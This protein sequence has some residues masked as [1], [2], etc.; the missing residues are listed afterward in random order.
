[1]M[2]CRWS[3]WG[4]FRKVLM[5]WWSRWVLAYTNFWHILIWGSQYFFFVWFVWWTFDPIYLRFG[6]KS[7]CYLEACQS[8]HISSGLLASNSTACS[9]FCIQFHFVVS[10]LHSI[11]F[12]RAWT[13]MDSLNFFNLIVSRILCWCFSPEFGFVFS[14]FLSWMNQIIIIIIF[15]IILLLFGVFLFGMEKITTKKSKPKKRL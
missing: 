10:S 1:M 11:W 4:I 9:S 6:F 7:L 5:A 8:H 12:G 2:W 13:W 14:S 15:I 3:A